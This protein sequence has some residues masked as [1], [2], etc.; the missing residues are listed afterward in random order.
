LLAW[1]DG[2]LKWHR[3]RFQ[4][5]TPGIGCRLALKPEE[6]TSIREEGHVSVKILQHLRHNVVGY[7][8]LFFAMGLG[9][10]W[11]LE[12]NS[13]KSKHIVD[14][15]VKS[16]DV[17]DDVLAGGGLTGDD[18]KESTLAGVWR[19]G[20]KYLLSPSTTGLEVGDASSCDASE[21]CSFTLQ[22]NAGDGVVSGG[23]GG[24]DAGTRVN[25]DQPDPFNVDR[26]Y[27][28]WE[29][30]GTVDTLSLTAIC[31]QSPSP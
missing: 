27:I 20:N 11:A 14:D 29:N 26:W 12:V 13:V 17:R 22:C 30:D 7:V 28:E 19:P 6:G 21:T 8:A 31:I 3:G 23:V 15:Q 10:A 24:L 25:A 2:A 1:G 9:T 18:I 16:A 5:P 4:N